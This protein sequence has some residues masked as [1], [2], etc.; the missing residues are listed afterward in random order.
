ML[1]ALERKL[2]M[3]FLFVLSK[4]SITHN[5]SNIDIVAKSH[6]HR[7]IQHIKYQYVFVVIIFSCTTSEEMQPIIVACGPLIF[8]LSSMH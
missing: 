6:Y 5:I 4:G 1:C 3:Q 8:A 2:Q 7:L